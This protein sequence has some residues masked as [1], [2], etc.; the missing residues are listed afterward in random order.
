[1]TLAEELAAEMFAEAEDLDIFHDHH[2][3]RYAT[4][5]MAP[6]NSLIRILW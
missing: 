5:N 2:F 3:V 4:S 6:F 1:V